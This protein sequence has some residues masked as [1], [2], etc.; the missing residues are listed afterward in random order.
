MAQLDLT[1]TTS[2]QNKHI[3]KKGIAL[4]LCSKMDHLV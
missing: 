3:E 4:Y 1:A 2:V